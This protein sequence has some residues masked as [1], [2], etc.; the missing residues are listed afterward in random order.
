MNQVCRLERHPTEYEFQEWKEKFQLFIEGYQ[1]KDTHNWIK[2]DNFIV[3]CQLTSPFQKEEVNATEEKTP[4]KVS[5]FYSV[6]IWSD[7]EVEK[8]VMLSINW[9]WLGGLRK[10]HECW[11]P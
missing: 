4:K 1:T 5:P 7:W 2:P 3:N 10:N 9:L 8:A 11:M 6:Q